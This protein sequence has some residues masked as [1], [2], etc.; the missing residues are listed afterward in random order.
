MTEDQDFPTE[1]TRTPV[2]HFPLV[3]HTMIGYYLLHKSVAILDFGLAENL[4]LFCSHERYK[5][6]KS[7]S[8]FIL[9]PE[10]L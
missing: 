8:T 5:N 3:L 2:N 4:R 1:F 6:Y 9:S 7:A 10:Q